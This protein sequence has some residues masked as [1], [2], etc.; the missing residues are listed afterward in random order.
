MPTQ[1]LAFVD[2]SQRAWL[3]AIRAL[4][5]EYGASLGVDLS[6]QGF[7]RE[8]EELPG[9]YGPP[10][11][12]LLLALVDG[13]PAGSVALR[14]LGAADCELKRLYVRPAFRGLGLGRTLTKSVLAAARAIG[15][16]RVLLDTL[17]SMGTAQDLYRSL[18]FVVTEPYTVNPVAGAT[19]M[20]LELAGPRVERP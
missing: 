15:Y 13:E 1:Q 9:A 7:E 3:P 10:A 5:A 19:F 17:P 4:I 12:R 8:L 18:G 14:P 2:G 16:R 20:A 11:G 6:F